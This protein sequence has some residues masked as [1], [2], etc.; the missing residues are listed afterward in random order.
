MPAT[1]IQTTIP[2]PSGGWTQINFLQ[3]LEQQ[4]LASFPNWLKVQ[5]DLTTAT[6][7]W[8]VWEVTFDSIK[9]YKKAYIQVQI[10]SGLAVSENLSTSWNT[11]TKAG[12]D[13]STSMAIV[14]LSSSQSIQFINYHDPAEISILNLFHNN[15]YSNI[16]A[17]RIPSS[18]WLDEDSYPAFGMLSQGLN[19]LITPKL[20]PF[21]STASQTINMDLGDATMANPNPVNSI[22][23]IMDFVWFK[24][25]SNTGRTG[26]SRSLCWGCAN[27]LTRFL[28]VSDTAQGSSV[29]ADVLNN[30]AGGLLIYV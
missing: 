16:N 17:Y 11:T 24:N 1:K 18:H 28:P 25:P 8:Q 21:S 20:N 15:V 4:I 27:G 12:T 29:K 3:T 13:T 9:L 2:S 26:R 5:E 23:D 7:K 6:P 14:T 19:S 10:T 30:V 22:R